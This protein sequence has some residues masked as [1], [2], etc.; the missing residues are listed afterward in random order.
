M[1]AGS[2]S[3]LSDGQLLERFSSRRDELAFS[4]LVE[5]YGG[6]V[7]GTCR[8]L[9][10]STQDAEDAF[11][12][13]FFVLARRARALE[14]SEPLGGW[15]HTVAY[16]IALKARQDAARRR[17]HERRAA[18]MAP[19]IA[20]KD[21][22]WE[23]LRPVLDEELEQLP[24][25]YRLPL[26]LCYL[27]G[28][29]N[30]QAAAELGWPPGSM[31]RRLSRARE[32]IRARLARRGVIVPAALLGA[33]AVQKASA[34]VPATLLASATRAAVAFGHGHAAAGG[35][36]SVRAAA[37]AEAILK[38]VLMTKLK[39]LSALVVAA[40]L[41]AGSAAALRAVSVEPE[42]TKPPLAEQSEPEAKKDKDVPRTGPVLLAS[43]V[44]AIMDAVR[45]NHL[46]PPA[47]EDMVL[48][49]ARGLVTA[50]GTPP[51]DE[52][53]QRAAAVT[54]EGQLAALF[55]DVWPGGAAGSD[56][57]GKLAAATLDALF[58]SIP[59]RPVPYS[60]AQLKLTEQ[61]RENRYVGLGVQVG[62]NK[63]EQFPAFAIPFRRGAA[64]TGGVRPGDLILEIDG[65][66]TKGVFDLEKVAVWLR[67]EAGS[68]VS[69]VVRQPGS[70]ETRPLKLLR[71]PIPI[72]SVY[73]F[74]RAGE[75]E[76]G[77]RADQAVAIGYLWV[78]A[79]KNSTLHEL[80]QA[81]RRLRAEGVRALV[82]DLRFSAGE[83]HLQDGALVADGL[84]DGG[85]MWSVRGDNT[86]TQYRADREALFRGWPLVA[87]MNDT[88][89][90][91][92]A[93]VLA[94]L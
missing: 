24:E 14:R 1:S 77:Y 44:W 5:R 71:G 62:V 78:K 68:S 27:Q 48:A 51:P 72:D 31:S 33:G 55:G 64:R 2:L 43:R 47:E 58:E 26:V 32:R 12:A 23:E 21:T 76:W 82:L 20:E 4:A 90:N 69:V 18:T 22:G 59:G 41:V 65:K 11:Q 30:A 52:L 63:K 8:R 85:L 56:R 36:A 83:G 37:W 34:A 74:R 42:K 40:S 61:L 13:T 53:P 7:W 9:L 17:E 70:A 75:D 38:G 10:A 73:G 25:K 66:S 94:A 91:V 67:G 6:L 86:V 93:L 84:L 29:T 35:T 50:A 28:K 39:G 54:T 45:K 19:V 46:E 60:T 89:D 88:L 57:D 79:I 49:S 80:R 16:R 81:E 3:G 92:P 15:L 87:L